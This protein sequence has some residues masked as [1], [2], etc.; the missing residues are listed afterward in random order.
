MNYAK[1]LVDSFVG[2]C[3]HPFDTTLSVRRF[4]R[5]T[6]GN[7]VKPRQ[8]LDIGCGPKPNNIF[9][10][11]VARGVDIISTKDFRVVKA[12]LITEPIP[13]ADHTFDAVTAFDFI[14]HVPRVISKEGE[15]CFPFIDLMNEI[16][17]V[18]VAGGV[19]LLKTP[20][21]PSLMAYKDPTHVNLL[22]STTVRDYF[23]TKTD[24]NTLPGAFMYGYTGKFRHLK[25]RWL[26]GLWSVTML[27]KLP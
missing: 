2:F 8:S 1:L 18:L 4:V 3:N 27:Q 16:Y 7:Y 12:N 24:Q 9:N 6:S 21:V 22:T 11:E 14:E 23:C 15:T 26:L 5:S 25:T 17:R 20:T 19:L 10:S 13:F